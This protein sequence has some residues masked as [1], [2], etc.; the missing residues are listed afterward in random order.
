MGSKRKDQGSEYDLPC[1]LGRGG[2]DAGRIS[3]RDLTSPA[4]RGGGPPQG[5]G[6]VAVV[7]NCLP[8]GAQCAPRDRVRA[9]ACVGTSIACPAFGTNAIC[10]RQIQPGFII[11]SGFDN[12]P[13]RIA[14]SGNCSPPAN[15][16][17]EGAAPYRRVQAGN[18]GR[19]SAV[20]TG[21][22]K[23]ETAD[24]RVPPPTDGCKRETADGRVPSLQAGASLP[25]VT[26]YLLLLTCYRCCLLCRA[27]TPWVCCHPDSTHRSARSL[28]RGRR[29][30]P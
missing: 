30:D 21:G 24:G 1:L 2:A 27:D 3:A 18:G 23:R 4:C 16:G 22:R 29:C 5:G 12:A 7:W 19:Q 20:P 17:V 25:P 13:G 9:S 28:R 6:G 8:S 11:I 15:R 26:S 10:R 14:L